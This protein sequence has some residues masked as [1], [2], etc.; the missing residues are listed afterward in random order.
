MVKTTPPKCN[1][2][3]PPLSTSTVVLDESIDCQ[4]AR[5]EKAGGANG[6]VE[7]MSGREARNFYTWFL[8]G[9]LLGILTTVAEAMLPMRGLHAFILDWCLLVGLVILGIAVVTSSPKLS[10]RVQVFRE[11]LLLPLPLLSGVVLGMLPG[12]FLLLLVL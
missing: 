2:S 7:H 6:Y 3:R 9:L 4:G 8:G 1:R 5:G 11:L 12:S 10:R